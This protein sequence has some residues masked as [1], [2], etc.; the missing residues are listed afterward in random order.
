VLRPLVTFAAA[1]V[2]LH[3]IPAYATPTARLVYSR[4]AD[5]ASCP[6]EEALREAIAARVGYDPF[7]PWARRTVVAS[8]AREDRAYV[9]KID[10]VDE[11]G[12]D[13]GARALRTEGPCSDLLDTVALAIAIAID[14]RSLTRAPSKPSEAPSPEGSPA[15]ETRE[16]GEAS[17]W[18]S[19]AQ[20]PPDSRPAPPGAPPTERPLAIGDTPH[21]GSQE[22]GAPEVEAFLGA[23]VS[24]AVAPGPA[25]GLALGSALRWKWASLG[26]DAR[27]DAP[28]AEARPAGGSVSSWLVVGTLAPCAHFGPLLVPLLACGLVQAG[29]MQSYGSDVVVGGHGSALWFATGARLGAGIRLSSRWELRARGDLVFD[30]AP[31]ALRLDGVPVWTSSWVAGS[32]ALDGVVHFR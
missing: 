9:A 8:L 20:P 17:A 14:P 32:L 11:Q 22:S 6:N 1:I 31:T 28:S 3:A 4:T 18:P 12:M 25:V 26:V 29:S 2:T 24:D 21:A 15:P 10:L 19:P 7:F 16:T 27:V 13:H 23:V 5:A 30:L